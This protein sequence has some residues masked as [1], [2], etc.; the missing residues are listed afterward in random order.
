MVDRFEAF[1]DCLVE[2]SEQEVCQDTAGGQSHCTRGAPL[3]QSLLQAQIHD[4]SMNIEL[5]VECDTLDEPTW[6]LLLEQL[7]QISRSAAQF[8]NPMLGL[9]ALE[10][11]QGLVILSPRARIRRLRNARAEFMRL[12]TMSRMRKC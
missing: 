7:N 2:C 1:E 9:F 12:A 8:G 10:L 11:E 6:R 4:A 5:A 3:T